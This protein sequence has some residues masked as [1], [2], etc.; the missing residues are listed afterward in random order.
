MIED[1]IIAQVTTRLKNLL[2]DQSISSY[3][4][5]EFF[6]S[7]ADRGYQFLIWKLQPVNLEN[8]SKEIE[9]LVNKNGYE[10]IPGACDVSTY[11]PDNGTGYKVVALY[12]P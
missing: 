8:F 6:Y 3:R 5:H 11:N 12:K 4:N 2:F 1:E 10:L 7:E 9:Q